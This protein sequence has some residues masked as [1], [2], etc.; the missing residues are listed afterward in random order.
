M[1]KISDIK[2]I[3]VDLLK[4]KPVDSQKRV[5]ESYNKFLKQF[6]KN[7]KLKKKYSDITSCPLCKKNSTKD[8]FMTVDGFSYTLCDNCQT[9]F[10]SPRLKIEYLDKMYKNGE[11]NNYSKKLVSTGDLIRTNTTEVRKFEQINS[12][13]D[14]CGELLDIGCGTGVFLSIAKKNGWRCIG[15]EP[16]QAASKI[17]N[18]SIGNIFNQSFKKFKIKKKF[19]CIS[20]WGVLEHLTDPKEQLSKAVGMLK[21]NGVIVFEVPSSDSILM[22]Y[23]AKYKLTPFRFIESS[24]HLTFFSKKAI[25]NICIEN[26]LEIEYIES[27]GLDLQTVLLQEFD[28]KTIESIMNLQQIIDKELL[29]DHYRVFLR[30]KL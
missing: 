22:Q 7:G 20:F 16:S 21:K 10:N 24:R 6:I 12:L 4:L 30:K 3:K 27:N 1:N 13:F 11:Y 17:A 18:D 8:S 19:D 15:V 29:S 5:Y 23:V 26:N 9:I 2:R 25:E 28:D 14:S